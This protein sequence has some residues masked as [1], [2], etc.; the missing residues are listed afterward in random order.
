MPPSPSNRGSSGPPQPSADARAHSVRVCAHIAQSIALAD[1][2]ISF[3]DYMGAALYAPGLGYYV[4]GSR[5]FGAEAD[6]VTAPELTPLFG[7]TV[8]AQAQ[9]ILAQVPGGELIELGAGTGRLAGDMLA[10]LASCGALPSRYLLL[11]VSPELRE[12]QR[13]H[14]EQRVPD[15]MDRVEWIDA[16]PTTWRGAVVANEVLDAIPPHVVARI[17]GEWFE[18][19]VGIDA[20]GRL[21]FVDRPLGGGPLRDAAQARFPRQGD[22][23]SEMNPAAQALVTALAQRCECGALLLLDYG[24]P[25]SEYYHPQRSSGTLMAHFR[26]YMS[27]DPFLFPGL[28]D[29]T[30][31]VD[32]TAIARAAVSGG[33]TV[34][35]YTTQA[36]FLINAGILDTLAQSADVNSAA[37][38]REAAAVQKLLSPAEMGEIFKTMAL[39]RGIDERLTGFREGDQAARL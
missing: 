8:A 4:A 37:Y 7:R 19:G 36:R 35:G 12:R 32:F 16:L 13:A 17:G 20:R 11:E 33:M 27:A 38:L 10:E 2:W 9:E 34:A 39:T 30:A 3:A 15:L 1:G 6:F 5:K 28:A 25:A 26:H 14:L 21:A 31:H 23:V 24:F 29:L 22:Y 18:R